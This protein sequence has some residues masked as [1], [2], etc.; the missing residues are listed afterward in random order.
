MSVKKVKGGYVVVHTHKAG[1]IGKRIDATKHPVSKAKALSI[2]RA[3]EASKHR[4]GR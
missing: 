1:S 4:R 2:H 3:I